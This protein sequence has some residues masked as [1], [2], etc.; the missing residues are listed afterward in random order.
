MLDLQCQAGFVKRVFIRGH[1]LT[2]GE[3][4]GELTAVVGQ[5]FADQHGGSLVQAA[6]E[7]CAASLGLSGGAG[8]DLHP[9]QGRGAG[10]GVDVAHAVAPVSNDSIKP[11]ITSRARNSGQLLVGK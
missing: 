3:G 9:Q 8:F 11:A 6:Q 10:L 4:V 1:T 5:D 7:V 2:R